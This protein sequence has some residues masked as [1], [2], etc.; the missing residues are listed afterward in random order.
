MATVK[1]AAAKPKV[2]KPKV[3][4]S[5]PKIAT[6][7]KPVAKPKPKNVVKP[8]PKAVAKPKAKVVTVKPRPV[9]RKAKVQLTEFDVMIK[10]LIAIP[11][12]KRVITDNDFEIARKQWL[13]IINTFVKRWKAIYDKDWALQ[14]AHLALWNALK[15]YNGK[16]KFTTYIHNC[17][18][19]EYMNQKRNA[20]FGLKYGLLKEG[21]VYD[22]MTSKEDPEFDSSYEMKDT[23]K[24]YLTP[25]EKIILDERIKG[26][27]FG[28]IA[29]ILKVSRQRAHQMLCRVQEKVMRLIHEK[30]I[31]IG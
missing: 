4:V 10:R 2:S 8:K 23:I 24:K 29:K 12:G 13:P 6:K 21:E 26:M 17:M 1:K 27:Q 18:N 14:T 22:I 7:P 19:W 28:E 11:Q 20:N 16:F 25:S 30:K 31:T 3:V 15:R 9:A 5:K